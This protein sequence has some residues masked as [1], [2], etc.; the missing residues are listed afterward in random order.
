MK[1]VWTPEQLG[2][3][4]TLTFDE[5][6]LLKRKAV[7]GRLGFWGKSSVATVCRGLSITYWNLIQYK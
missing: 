2:T 7:A 5:L 3:S 1:Q 4:W 6:D